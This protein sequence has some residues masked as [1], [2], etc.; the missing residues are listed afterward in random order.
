MTRFLKLVHTRWFKVTVIVLLCLVALKL[1]G[2]PLTLGALG[3]RIA[4][5]LADMG[6]DGVTRKE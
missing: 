6:A 2:E 1:K 3:A 4:D 5:L